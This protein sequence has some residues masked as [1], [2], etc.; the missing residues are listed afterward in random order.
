MNAVLLG[1][2]DAFP[3]N[4]NRVIMVQIEVSPFLVLRNPS[5]KN[6]SRKRTTMEH[7]NVI[8]WIIEIIEQNTTIMQRSNFTCEPKIDMF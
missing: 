5:S 7:D 1:V 4:R 8:T 2:I 6:C 3:P